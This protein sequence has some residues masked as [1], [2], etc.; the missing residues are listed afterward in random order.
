MTGNVLGL[1]LI[2]LSALGIAYFY[3]ADHERRH[4]D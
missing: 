3:W 2:V 4:R 1:V